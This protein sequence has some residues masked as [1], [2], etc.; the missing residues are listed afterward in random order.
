MARTG[1]IT[2]IRRLR[3]LTNATANDAIINGVAYF[4]DDHL[5]AALDRTVRLYNG[6][7]L[8]P[9][10]LA[11]GEVYEYLIP[12][13]RDF[14]EQ[15]TDSGWALRVGNSIINPTDYSA[16]YEARRVRFTL[17]QRG[18]N[19]SLDARGYNMYLAAAEVCDQKAA[20]CAIK[21]DWRTEKQG[22]LASQEYEHWLTMARRYRALAGVQVSRLK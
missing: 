10:P 11:T 12:V 13:G 2:M 18:A 9:L 4:T 21:T 17:N 19:F 1:M 15:A 22:T 6:V 8:V 7:P 3:A 5:Q 16:N 14:E 20:F